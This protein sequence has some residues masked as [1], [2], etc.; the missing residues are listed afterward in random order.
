MRRHPPRLLARGIVSDLFYRCWLIEFLL[1][2]SA[3]CQLTEFLLAMFCSLTEFLVS[4]SSSDS[5]A[6]LIWPTG[7]LSNTPAV[8]LRLLRLLLLLFPTVSP[9]WA[10]SV[11]MWD[12][13]RSAITEFRLTSSALM[14]SLR[15][16]SLRPS[17][18][19]PR[20]MG[21]ILLSCTYR[22]YWIINS[23]IIP[24]RCNNCVYSSQ[25]LYS[26]CFGRQFH[27]SSGVQCCI[28]PFR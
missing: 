27:P 6:L 4:S 9:L 7:V 18:G 15:R 8:E 24:T 10:P 1:P 16:V 22:A 21:E 3:S 20:K 28:G 13:R 12:L 14:V 17:T 5:Y 19:V 26:T 25:W 11:F 2:F 23:E